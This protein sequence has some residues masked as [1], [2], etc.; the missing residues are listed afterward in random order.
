MRKNFL[1]KAVAVAAGLGIALTASVGVANADP[2]KPGD[3]YAPQGETGTSVSFAHYVEQYGTPN[4]ATVHVTSST[5]TSPSGSVTIVLS[6]KGISRTWSK[7]LSSSGTASQ[8]LPGNLP[9][10]TYSVSASYAGNAH[11]QVSDGESHFS[12]MQARGNVRNVNAKDIHVGQHG[13]VQGFVDGNGS[14][15]TGS[16]SI[17]VKRGTSTVATATDKLSSTGHYFATLKRFPHRGNFSVTVRYTGDSHYS[18]DS[19]SGSF[20]VSR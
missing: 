8:G 4:V 12:V 11:Y 9:V 13:V 2:T 1:A 17:T 15:P 3:A 20:T 7:Q 14:T 6:G 18:A 10:G 5:K 16:V 19:G